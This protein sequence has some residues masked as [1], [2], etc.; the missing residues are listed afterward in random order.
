MTEI[1]DEDDIEIQKTKD[2]RSIKIKD[3]KNE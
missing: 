1:R 2:E 3:P